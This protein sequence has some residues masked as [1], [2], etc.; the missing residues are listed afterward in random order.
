LHFLTA[1][2]A[3]S[4]FP[5][6]GTLRFMKHENNYVAIMAGGIGSRFW[7]KSR[8]AHPKQFL[9][10]LDIGK[11]L[12]QMTYERFLPL[13]PKENIYVITNER[14]ADLV[15][16]QLP[17]LADHQILRE[18][19]RRNTAPC[20][21]Y[22]SHKIAAVNPQARLVVAPSDHIVMRQEV[23]L[24]ELRRGL[25]FVNSRDALVT[26]G[27]RPTRPDTG[28]GYIQFLEDNGKDDVYK[29]KTFTEKPTPEIA[30]SF[31][32]SGDF[33]WNSGIFIWSVKSILKAFKQHLAEVDEVFRQG[34]QF[35]NTL[36]EAEFI[37]KAYTL[38]K[39]ISIDYGV[40]EKADNVHVIPSD[41]GWSDLGT[42]ASLYEIYEKDYLGNAVS[43]DN[44][45]I[46]DAAH[47]M[48]MAPDDKLVVLQGLD[49][50]CV[51]DTGDVL[52]ICQKDR[53]QE[54][55]QMTTDVKLKKGERYL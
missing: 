50:Y 38:C 7:P 6:K 40:M 3:K 24:D 41:F 46:Y 16:E 21:A 4:G 35:Y 48:V 27:I 31:L 9:D 54:I 25:Q 23:F 28:Y 30:K 10:I 32:K 8:V 44:V 53:E 22:V 52:L 47:C 15:K 1:A 34:K 20:V 51:I 29:V 5:I 2:P 45:M 55:K 19:L 36:E 37:A 49:D 33:L 18:P 17:D 13:C 14:Y 12:I 42:W 43:G 11:T 39:N 26:P